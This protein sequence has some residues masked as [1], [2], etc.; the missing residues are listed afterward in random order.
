MGKRNRLQGSASPPNKRRFH[1]RQAELEYR[2]RVERRSKLHEKCMRMFPGE[3]HRFV[4]Y[5]PEL[6]CEQSEGDTRVV[7]D[8]DGQLLE[9]YPSSEHSSVTCGLLLALGSATDEFYELISEYFWFDLE[10]EDVTEDDRCAIL[11][12]IGV[13]I[14]VPELTRDKLGYW[15]LRDIFPGERMATPYHIVPFYY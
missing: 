4:D 8:V 2:R 1:C 5:D 14:N 12:H 13:M 11:D 6:S 9:F 10:E 3:P 7:G 15:C